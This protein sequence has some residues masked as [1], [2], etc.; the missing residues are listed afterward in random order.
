MSWLWCLRAGRI[1]L[2]VTQPTQ[3][4]PRLKAFAC[5]LY[6]HSSSPGAHQRVVTALYGHAPS[7][8]TVLAAA[9]QLASH[10][11]A[12]LEQIR[13]Q[14]LAAPVVHFDESGLRVDGR[15]RWLHVASTAKLTHYTSTINGTY[16]YA[17][18]RHLAPLKGR[19]PACYWRSYFKF[20]TVGI[21]FAT[22]IICASCVLSLSSTTKLGRHRWNVCCWTSKPK[23]QRRQHCTL[24]CHQTDWAHYEAQYDALIAQGFADN[25]STAR[26]NPDRSA[27]PNSRRPKTCTRLHKHKAGRLSLLYDFR[28]PFDN[29]LSNAT[30]A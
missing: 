2:H 15:L 30:C 8:P 26:Q 22:S 21:A 3:Y 28:I 24:P 23:S 4:G 25:P 27:D 6:S 5:Y 16:R 29:N 12:S 1:S 20:A 14:L 19:C 18:R 10:T 13:Q 7:E 9:R 17:C 11:Q